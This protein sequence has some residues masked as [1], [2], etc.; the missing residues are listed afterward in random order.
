MIFYL[1]IRGRWTHF[2]WY[3]FFKAVGKK[4]HQPDFWTSFPG[5]VTIDRLED[6]CQKTVRW[7]IL[8][9]WIQIGTIWER[10][11]AIDWNGARPNTQKETAA[12]VKNAWIR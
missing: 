6:P 2:D 9:P 5:G 1:P 3:I 8:V 7:Q 4:N 10:T 11:P 12:K